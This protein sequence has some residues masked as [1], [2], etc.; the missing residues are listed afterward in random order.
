MDWDTLKKS[1]LF[2]VVIGFTALN[3]SAFLFSKYIVHQTTQ[4]V[5]EKLQKE[6][7]PS[8]YGPGFDPDKMNLDGLKQPA[9]GGAI[10]VAFTEGQQDAEWEADWD[11]QRGFNR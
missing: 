4:R 2:W 5:L 7:S 1:V 10:P 6:Y 11:K 3:L 9:P 8:P